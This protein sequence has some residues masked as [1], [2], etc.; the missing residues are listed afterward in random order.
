[1]HQPNTIVLDHNLPEEIQIDENQS[2]LSDSQRS[3]SSR[4]MKSEHHSNG[5]PL[6]NITSNNTFDSTTTDTSSIAAS[7]SS[8][9]SSTVSTNGHSLS[10]ASTFS[11]TNISYSSTDSSSDIG[12]NSSSSDPFSESTSNESMMTIKTDQSSP[13]T[14]KLSRRKPPKIIIRRA[15]DS[16]SISSNT[17]NS[18]IT[19]D[20]N[21]KSTEKQSMDVHHL[22]S[23]K[24]RSRKK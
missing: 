6:P 19:I 3:I 21:Q 1:L 24:R 13:S 5:S 15:S 22:S 4:E 12:L 10:S 16:G 11:D 23:Y 2:N 8:D 20:G 18:S 9:K 17:K 14:K 7:V